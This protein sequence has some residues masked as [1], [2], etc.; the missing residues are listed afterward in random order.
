MK[1]F[2]MQVGDRVTNK[3]S[4]TGNKFRRIICDEG[5]IKEIENSLYDIET[6]KIECIGENGWYTVYEKKDLLTDEEREFLKL[7]MKINGIK[8]KKIKFY[9]AYAEL[10]SESGTFTIFINTEKSFNKLIGKEY[11]LKD[12][13]LEEEDEQSR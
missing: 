7:Y 5:T 11:T 12:L 9:V 8:A 4:K 2:D 13:G 3:N 6:I 10:K 1:D